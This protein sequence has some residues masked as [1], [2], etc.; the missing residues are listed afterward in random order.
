MLSGQP[1]IIIG[2]LS[3]IAGHI[4]TFKHHSELFWFGVLSIIAGLI[5]L[6]ISVV[7]GD[8]DDDDEPDCE[9]EMCRKHRY[10]PND[11]K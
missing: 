4:F 1:I 11:Y 9:C 6:T 2:I 8:P 3:M 7:F 5:L 10:D